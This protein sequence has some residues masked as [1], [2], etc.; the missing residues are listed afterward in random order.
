M[1]ACYLVGGAIGAWL[2][3]RVVSRS[4]PPAAL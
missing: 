2:R 3:D 4:M 1:F